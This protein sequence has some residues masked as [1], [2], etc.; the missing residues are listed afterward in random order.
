MC[1]FAYFEKWGFLGR[2]SSQTEIQFTPHVLQQK[3]QLSRTQLY[4]L[5]HLHTPAVKRLFVRSP[6]LYLYYI[7]HGGL[8]SYAKV[9]GTGQIRGFVDLAIE[10]GIQH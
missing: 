9:K 6:T 2:S 4:L 8:F 3:H 7:V 10:L 5:S 1:E